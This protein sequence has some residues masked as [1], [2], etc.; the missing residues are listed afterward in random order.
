MNKFYDTIYHFWSKNYLE[1]FLTSQIYAL[2][3]IKDSINVFFFTAELI[4]ENEE[5]ILKEENF[6]KQLAERIKLLIKSPNI[7]VHENNLNRGMSITCFEN[8]LLFLLYTEAMFHN[9][10]LLTSQ[11]LWDYFFR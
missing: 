8:A 6:Q 9:L 10:V 4:I 2:T 5:S 3:V 11:L 1:I 7:L